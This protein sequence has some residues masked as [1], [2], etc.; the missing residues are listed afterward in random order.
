M[1]SRLREVLLVAQER[2]SKVFNEYEAKVDEVIKAQWPFAQVSVLP[3]IVAG[4]RIVEDVVWFFGFVWSR[5]G[6][7]PT[8]QDCFEGEWGKVVFGENLKMMK[9]WRDAHRCNELLIWELLA[10]HRFQDS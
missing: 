10:T 7:N 2:F 6:S 1:D 3:Y 9:L 8:L 4:A 5:H